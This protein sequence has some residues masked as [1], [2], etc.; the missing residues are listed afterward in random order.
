MINDVFALRIIFKQKYS[1]AEQYIR[2]RAHDDC[3]GTARMIFDVELT[4][5]KQGHLGDI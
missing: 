5:E 1:K 4:T 2:Q 3:H